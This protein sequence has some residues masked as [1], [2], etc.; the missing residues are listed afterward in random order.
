LLELIWFGIFFFQSGALL[1]RTES[2][3]REFIYNQACL[4]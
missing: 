4:N 2:I 1:G 3:P